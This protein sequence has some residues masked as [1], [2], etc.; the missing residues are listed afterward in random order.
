[1]TP[2]HLPPVYAGDRLTVYLQL[3]KENVENLKKRDLTMK[4]KGKV[5]KLELSQTA[6]IRSASLQT[7]KDPTLKRYDSFSRQNQLFKIRTKKL[8]SFA[9]KFASGKVEL[10]EYE[11]KYLMWRKFDDN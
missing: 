2:F 8:L 1:M 10:F 4:L 11:S 5:G 9:A 6:S 7:Q 3:E